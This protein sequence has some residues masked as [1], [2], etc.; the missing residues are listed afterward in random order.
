MKV[1]IYSTPTCHFCKSAKEFFSENS[2]EFTDYNVAED[3]EKRKEM[4]ERSDQMGVPVIFVTKEGGESQ[5]LIGFD[6]SKLPAL[7]GI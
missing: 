3:M 4:I 6:Q 1:E 7:L 5:M 2:V